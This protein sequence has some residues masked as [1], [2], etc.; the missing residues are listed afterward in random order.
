M[1]A[2]PPR[3]APVH[4]AMHLDGVSMNS[5][6]TITIVVRA[7]PDVA[8]RLGRAGGPMQLRR[9]VNAYEVRAVP[10]RSSRGAHRPG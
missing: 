10:P 9:A 8:E 5:E 6:R 2:D 1:K 4:R 3:R 7:Q